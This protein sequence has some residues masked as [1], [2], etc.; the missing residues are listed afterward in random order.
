MTGKGAG[1]RV[2]EWGEENAKP[3][4]LGKDPKNKNVLGKVS[5]KAFIMLL[6]NWISEEFHVV[7]V[8]NELECNPSAQLQGQPG[9]RHRPVLGAV[10]SVSSQQQGCPVLFILWS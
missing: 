1:S 4:L 2:Q 5:G 10:P 6:F 9:L 8:P 3:E 7:F